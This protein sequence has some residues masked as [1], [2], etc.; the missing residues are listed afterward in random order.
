MTQL[1]R[2]KSRI[3]EL[4]GVR[5]V[6]SLIV[7]GVHFFEIPQTSGAWLPKLSGA[8]LSFGWS[9]VDLFFVLSG[10]LIGGIL[11]DNRYA[12]NY[13]RTFYVRRICRIFPL[14]FLWLALYYF[15]QSFL[16]YSPFRGGGFHLPKW[17]YLFFL[18]NFYTTGL[19]NFDSNWM[20]PTWSLAIEE[21][22][23]LLLPLVLWFAIPRKPVRVLVVLI[24]LVP[25]T[26]ILIFL[27]SNLYIKVLLPCRADSLLIGVLCAYLVRQKP[28]RE[29][30]ANN[31]RALYALLF[32]LSVGLGYLISIGY[33]YTANKVISSFEVSSYGFTLVALFYACVMVIGVVDKTTII[34][35]V[36]RIP[37]LRH[38]GSIAYGMYLIH[39]AIRAI[40]LGWILGAEGGDSTA[41]ARNL[42]SVLAFFVTWFIALM[43]WRY[44]EQP[45][46][47]WGHSFRYGPDKAGTIPVDTT[48]PAPLPAP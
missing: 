45:I 41:L 40:L 18:Q 48:A 11:I 17:G 9:G 39:S 23:Y 12:P 16:G 14:Y 7:V 43:S 15:I 32:V 3:P 26:R 21:Q 27:Y 37:L 1:E 36:L 29:W 13:F 34:A 31:V 47:R 4:D 10:F 19:N 33:G 35:R 2:F 5:G 30:L 24:A 25:I 46:V 28:A 6:A 22:F 42:V 20:G 8:I 44:F 38:F